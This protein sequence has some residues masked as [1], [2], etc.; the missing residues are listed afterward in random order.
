MH[1]FSSTVSSLVIN[2]LSMHHAGAGSGGTSIVDHA[3][4]H[5]AG[6]RVAHKSLGV[7]DEP[8]MHVRD[9]AK[10]NWKRGSMAGKQS[11]ARR[12]ARKGPSVTRST[13]A[14]RTK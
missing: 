1:A 8:T 2:I 3:I 12:Q 9:T 7:S 6:C 11:E 5:I 10:N 14:N 4:A 13:Q